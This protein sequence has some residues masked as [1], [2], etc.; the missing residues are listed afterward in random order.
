MTH[1]AATALLGLTA[2]GL[3]ASADLPADRPVQLAAICA[4]TAEQVAGSSRTC[5]YSCS[6]VGQFIVIGANQ[7]CPLTLP[8]SN[9]RPTPPRG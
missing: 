7:A 1:F 3:T 8:A 2:I 4:K 5:F 9:G 6:G